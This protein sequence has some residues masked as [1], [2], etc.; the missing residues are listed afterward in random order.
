[1]TNQLYSRCKSPSLQGRGVWGRMDT[2]V[3]MAESLFC[4]PETITTLLIGYTPIQS[5][6]YKKKRKEKVFLFVHCF[7]S[8]YYL[9]TLAQHFL[10]MI[11]PGL[12][13]QVHSYYWAVSLKFMCN[14]QHFLLKFFFSLL[15]IIICLY[16]SEMCTETGTCITELSTKAANMPLVKC[17]S[18]LSPPSASAIIWIQM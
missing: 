6:K 10:H 2:C 4:S 1:M 8:S 14:I 5:N 18:S 16:S 7:S 12:D 11:Y 15:F 9:I 17:L 13:L 3:S